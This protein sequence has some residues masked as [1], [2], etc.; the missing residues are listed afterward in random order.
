MTGRHGSEPPLAG[1]PDLMQAAREVVQQLRAA[2]RWDTCLA[3]FIEQVGTA[4]AAS[5]C[6][7]CQVEAANADSCTIHNC[8][9]WHDS[10]APMLPPSPIT[11][12]IPLSELQSSSIWDQLSLGRAVSDLEDCP[13]PLLEVL[14]SRGAKT[15]LCVPVYV[16]NDLWGWLGADDCHVE[17]T[18]DAVASSAMAIVANAFGVALEREFS[19]VQSARLAA[20]FENSEDAIIAKTT[21]GIVTEWNKAAEKIYGYT[22]GEMLG[23][24]IT[25]VIPSELRDQFHEIMGRLRAG[26][27]IE[28]LQTERI[29]KDGVRRHV[30][31]SISP[32]YDLGNHLTGAVTIARDVTDAYEAELRTRAS[33][34]RLRLALEAGNIGA[35]DW[36]ISTNE[37]VWSANMERLHGLEP[38]TFDGTFD[39]YREGIHP[40]DEQRVIDA[41]QRAVSGVE[42]YDL[43]YRSLQSE[44]NSIWLATHGSVIR[45][46]LGRPIRMTGVCFDVTLRKQAEAAQ[47]E[48][49]A[50]VQHAR[51]EADAEVRRLRDLFQ[52]APAMM[53]LLEGP[54]HVAVMVNDR[55]STAVGNR[56]L[57]NKPLIEAVPEIEGQGLIELLDEVYRTGVT[58]TR[59]ELP[60]WIDITGTGQLEERF[61]SFAYQPFRDATN[62][63]TGVLV[64]AVDLTDHVR[65]RQRVEQLANAV[66]WERDRLQQVVDVMPEG[67]A[68]CNTEGEIYLS[69][70]VAREIWGQEQPA[71]GF[72]SYVH[73]YP[74]TLELEPYPVDDLPLTRSVRNGETVLGEQ[75]IIK[76]VK[77]GEYIYVLVNS[78]PLRD[79]DDEIIGGVVVFQDIRPLR[80][81]ERQ[82]DEFLQAVTHDLKNPLTTILGNVQLIQRVGQSS[83][84]RIDAAVENIDS[85]TRRAI[86]LVDEILDL[87]RLQMGRQLEMSVSEVNLVSMVTQICEQHRSTTQQHQLSVE[88]DS[89]DVSGEWDPVRL[90]RVIANLVSNAINYSPEGGKITVRIRQ[91]LIDAGS[92]AV[93]EVQ[94]QGMGIPANEISHLFERFWRGSNVREHVPGTGLGLAGAKAIVEAHGG[95][96][97][98]ESVEG[99]GSTFSVRLPLNAA[100]L[101]QGSG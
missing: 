39:A 88:A 15:V 98:V 84:E 66:A 10:N 62:T 14:E 18:W 61:F 21:E 86:S 90:Q 96:I 50:Q 9:E 46:L 36:N 11:L 41:I 71:G 5:R 63:V 59:S 53:L 57:L 26:E 82:K 49:L 54:D 51:A 33:E 40:D 67:V 30:S 22:R 52:H 74:L 19:G 31:L 42:E 29:R 56:E 89:A 87:T 2:G 35:W 25:Q 101:P 97:F 85:A 99:E 44:G 4:T 27:R 58:I 3:S 79:V 100:A 80:E 95:E 43:E 48:L 69:N 83:P 6:Y 65:S 8:V 75:F 76:N 24:S 1:E 45:D 16:G 91:E 81:F 7:V 20:I 17:Q 34:E 93:I 38:G 12:E 92:L 47:F 70:A 72:E 94:D 13:S 32:I 77:T 28:H 37:V 60:T 73:L 23:N 78:A 64:H 68:I 55:Y